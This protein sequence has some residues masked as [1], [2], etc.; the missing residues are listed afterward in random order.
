M[1]YTKDYLLASMAGDQDAFSKLYEEIYPDLYKMAVYLYGRTS[2]AED[3]VS[4]T[5]ID[6]YKGI[7]QLKSP[8]S[9]DAWIFRILSLK[10]K[11]KFKHQYNSFSNE[12]PL[13]SNMENAE[14]VISDFTDTSIKHQDLLSALSILKPMDRM[15]ISLC[16]IEGYQSNEVG[17]MLSMKASSVRSRLNRS[18][19]KIKNELEDHRYD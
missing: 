3:L 16:I 13:A 11:R 5:V 7:N 14:I 10:A 12:N 4:E 9:F 1:K 8:D 19:R 18:L 15:I 2:G 17:K 6:A